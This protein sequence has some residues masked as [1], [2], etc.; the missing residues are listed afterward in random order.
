MR[1]WLTRV[2]AA[3]QL[4]TKRDL[5]GSLPIDGQLLIINLPRYTGTA[6]SRYTWRIS[7][8]FGLVVRSLCSSTVLELKHLP[9]PCGFSPLR[10]KGA[11]LSMNN[12]RTSLSAIKLWTGSLPFPG[13]PTGAL[14]RCGS[15]TLQWQP[16]TWSLN[17]QKLLAKR[18]SH[19]Q[20]WLS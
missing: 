5:F 7:N 9:F 1:L 16:L 18:L 3:R 15:R 19:W 20:R 10:G 2:N 6:L 13:M 4:C 11:L 14:L 12:H 17:Y 8:F